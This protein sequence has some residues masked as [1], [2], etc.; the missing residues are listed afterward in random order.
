MLTVTT[1]SETIEG[2]PSQMRLEASALEAQINALR[3]GMA[4]AAVADA[5]EPIK[6][7]PGRK[8]KAAPPETFADEPA[9]ETVEADE[10]MG[11]DAPT[12]PPKLADKM[13]LEECMKEFANYVGADSDKRAKAKKV[14]NGF[15]VKSLKDL[16]EQYRRA[17]VKL[18]KA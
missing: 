12:A 6:G 1:T 9:T 15:N 16:G 2:L 5:D 18:L 10:D 13:S 7:K 8:P 3:G 4:K 17:A 14:L 11:F